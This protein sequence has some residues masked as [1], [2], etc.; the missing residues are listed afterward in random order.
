[1]RII[2]YNIFYG[3]QERMPLIAQ[4]LRDQQPDLVALQE[5]ND[6]SLAE[7]LATTLHMQ[8]IFGESDNIFRV[9]WLSRLPVSQVRNY[10]LPFLFQGPRTEFTMQKTLLNLEV[11]WNGSPL[12]LYTTHLQARYPDEYEECRLREVEAILQEIQ[13]LQNEPL[14]LVGDLNAFAPDD[15]VGSFPIDS[16]EYAQRRFIE[17]GKRLA[18]ARL[19]AAGLV[20]CYRMLHPTQPGYTCDAR[21]E[22]SMRSDYCFASA[23]LAQSLHSCAVISNALTAKASDH[24]PVQ[25]EFTNK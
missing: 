12:H 25:V 13:P 23:P 21:R 16:V 14:L 9:A 19:K 1:M 10:Q 15:P 20:D 8:L 5:A 17:Q 4:I 22:P 2:T 7:Q 18:I 24:L 6:R 3:G 11:E